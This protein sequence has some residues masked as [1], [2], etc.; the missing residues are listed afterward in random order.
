[1]PRVRSVSLSQ[2]MNSR[3]DWLS[4]I[5]KRPY[6]VF[7]KLSDINVMG[8]SNAYNF[9]NEHPDSINFGDLAVA[10]ND[11]VAPTRIYI[12]DYPASN[13]NGAGTISFA[14]GHAELHKWLDERTTPP[15]TNK[16]LRLVVPSAHNQDMVYMSSKASVAKKQQ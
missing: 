3:N 14:D 7:R 4:F 15:V 8:T 13:H 16:L 12:I 11:G 9:I 1:M 2:A 6:H 10:M 5:T